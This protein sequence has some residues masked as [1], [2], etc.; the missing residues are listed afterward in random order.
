[1]HIVSRATRVN[2]TFSDILS[3]LFAE[4]AEFLLVGGYALAAHGLPRA[5]GDIDIWV[6]PTPENA[7]RVWAALQRF[8]APLSRLTVEDLCAP[9]VVF[10]MGLP[11]ERVDILTSITGVDF[12]KAWPR[13]KLLN[14]DSKTLPVIAREDLIQNKRAAGRP[15]DLADVARLEELP[16]DDG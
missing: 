4:N 7:K 2:P 13:R 14:L 3:A 5:T 9:D 16:S 6:R 10:Q 1:M 15:Q 8:R 11:P 12:E